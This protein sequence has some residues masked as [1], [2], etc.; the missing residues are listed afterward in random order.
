MLS[1]KLFCNFLYCHRF[2]VDDGVIEEDIEDNLTHPSSSVNV[3]SVADQ[4]EILEV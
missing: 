4:I 1:I 2:Q 3:M